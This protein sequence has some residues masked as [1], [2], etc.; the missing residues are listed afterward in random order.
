MPRIKVNRRAAAGRKKRGKAVFKSQVIRPKLG[1]RKRGKGFLDFVKNAAKGIY[2]VGKKVAEVLKPTGL[3]SK[4]AAMLPGI[5]PAASAYLKTQGYGKRKRHRKRGK[6]F[7]DFVKKAVNVGKNVA[8]QLKGTGVVS[9]L[10][11]QILPKGKFTTAATEF[12]KS[13]GYGRKRKRGGR[14]LIN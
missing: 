4:G 8:N 13:K 14:M 10:A 1:S 11:G 7:L 12:L 5:G 6:G 2:N 9:N 3:V